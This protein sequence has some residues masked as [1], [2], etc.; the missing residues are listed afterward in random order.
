MPHCAFGK[1]G[2]MVSSNIAGAAS[3]P[4]MM[5]DIQSW[6]RPP[7]PVASGDV[8]RSVASDK[9]LGAKDG[10][11]RLCLSGMGATISNKTGKLGIAQPV[12]FSKLSFYR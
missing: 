4:A 12:L 1:N 10:F 5:V 2:P 7:P 3:Y 6:F 11:A 8:T 9:E